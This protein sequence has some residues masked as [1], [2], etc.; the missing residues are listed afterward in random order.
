MLK[1]TLKQFKSA[2][3]KKKKKKK[4]N[5]ASVKKISQALEIKKIYVCFGLK[6]Y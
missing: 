1:Q 6:S 3:P 4:D 5:W 2:E